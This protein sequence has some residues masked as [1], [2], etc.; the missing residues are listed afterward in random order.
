MNKQ[1]ADLTIIN[2][3]LSL[4]DIP[5]CSASGSGSSFS[6]DSQSIQMAQNVIKFIDEMPG[7]FFIYRSDVKEQ[8]LYANQAVLRIFG[9]A[10]R[11]EFHELTGSSFKGFVHP[12]DL[13][14]VEKSIQEQI[15]HSQYDLDYVE[16]RI[17]RKDGEVR[18][19]EDYGHFVHNESIGDI[20]Y[21]FIGDATDKR[22]QINQLQI[23]RLRV[24]EGLSINYESILYADLDTDQ[25]LPYR[26]NP[27]IEPLFKTK[28]Q[29][30]GFSWCVLNYI[31]TWVHP[32]DQENVA[33]ALSP[34][35][36]RQ[37]LSEQK[38][39]YI[40]YRINDQGEC[41]YFQLRIV[42][43]DDR[44]PVSRIIIGSRRVDQEIQQEME[45]KQILE[46]A[47]HNANLAI[48]AKNTFLS[49]MSHDMRTPLNAIFGFA[50]LARAHLDNSMAVDTYLDKIETASRH[51]LELIEKVLEISWAESNDIDV[52]ESECNLQEILHQVYQL[53][54]PQAQEKS[55]SLS[56]DTSGL[57]RGDVCSDPDKLKQLFFNLVSNAVAYTEADG[58]VEILAKELPDSSDSCLVCQ[59]LVKDTGIGIANDFLEHIFEP[60]EREKNTTLSGIHGTGLGLTIAKNIVEKLG[61]TIDVHSQEGK[62]SVFTVTL[63][64]P[65]RQQPFVSAVEGETDVIA[66]FQNQK[67]L[68]VE[69]N[70]INQEM[71]S[72]IL[73][74]LGFLTEVAAN[75]KIAVE[76]LSSA[77]ADEY[78]LVLMDIQMPVMDGWEATRAIRLLDNPKLAQIPIIALSADAFE[79]NQKKSL[80]CGMD[81]HLCKPLDIGR[82]LETMAAVIIR[83]KNL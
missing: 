66:F 36:I 63:R 53:L 18:W 14:T 28:S 10:T 51:L 41:H 54:L 73:N 57:P 55:I 3:I 11:E 75:G 78:A 25:L 42:N 4:L 46:D 27:R 38:T 44:S 59:F 47:L 35:Y 26:L 70:E 32:L 37:K 15:S 9:C 34:E 67:I 62:G 58:K 65:I 24:I 50:S 22:N 71:E 1:K 76:K 61:G 5:T 43:T 56:L 6:P 69:D 23:Q 83:Q 74:D 60:F 39:Y 49:N 68:L 48:I 30:S 82:L 40:N 72:E 19:I 7:G 12:D 77:S 2:H 31:D 52:E 64:F 80:E 16:Y 21:V 13:E 79:S 17:I 29:A 81:A 33:R 45:Q 8:I 20:F